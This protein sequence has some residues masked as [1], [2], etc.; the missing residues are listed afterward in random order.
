[1]GEKAV[2]AGDSYVIDVLN[3]VAHQF[4]GDDCFFSYRDVAGSGRDDYD[5]AL[6]A[7]L[8]IALEHDGARQGTI[9]RA[10]H[11]VGECGGYGGVLFFGGTGG[12]HVAAVGGEAGEDGGH[13]GWC[14]AG[15]EDHLGHA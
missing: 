12:E 3:V 9:F 8:A 13:L 1:M 6:A 2:N 7:P 5:Y 11:M 4:G 14:F 15:C 10:A